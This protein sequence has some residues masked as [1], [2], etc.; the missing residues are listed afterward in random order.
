MN[1]RSTTTFYLFGKLDSTEEGVNIVDLGTE[2]LPDGVGF[3]EAVA[4]ALV[5]N[6]VVRAVVLTTVVLGVVV[7]D[8]DNLGLGGFGVYEVALG[9]GASLAL[10]DGATVLGLALHYAVGALANSCHRSR[11]QP[12]RS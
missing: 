11:H 5:G 1:A 4:R 10:G 2:R 8:V 9:V 7:V 3:T 12:S 6:K